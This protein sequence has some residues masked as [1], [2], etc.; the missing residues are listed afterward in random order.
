MFYRVFSLH[1]DIFTSFFSNSLI[2][3]GV[4][5]QI[6]DY[7]IVNWRDDFGVGNYKQVDDKPYGG[8]S[9]MVL[10]AEPIFKALEKYQAISKFYNPN[11]EPTEY[12]RLVPNNQ[13]FFE[14]WAKELENE[15]VDS[16][17]PESVSGLHV[18][19]LQ[20]VELRPGHLDRG[21]SSVSVEEVEVK[22]TKKITISLTPRGFP[23]NQ[24]IVEWLTNF[25]ELNILC[26]RYEG[27]DARVSD[28]VDLELS[29]GDFVLNGG[30]VGAMGLI[31]AVSRLLPEFV[32][33]G[34]SV[35]HDSFS[36]G[37]N[38]YREQEEFVIG[39]NRLKN[40]ELKIKNEVVETINP[41][42]NTCWLK[43]ILP[44]IEHPQFTRPEIW[45]NFK[46]PAVLINGDH[47]KIQ[48]W[49]KKWY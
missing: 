45:N 32:T 1:P 14:K 15:V 33:K 9:G 29:I 10:Q 5:K 44:K 8:G 20:G 18:V 25:D 24:Q 49:R 40:K 36:S 22:N 16:V 23:I 28:A 31:E 38:N 42:S 19:S 21:R 37:L 35:L 6:I 34:D 17:I 26:G 39:K 2:A 3:R 41:F 13:V 12:S 47:K 43:N 30:E 4:E 27:F 11:S 7:E 48:A 46:L